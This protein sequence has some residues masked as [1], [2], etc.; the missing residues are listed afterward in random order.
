MA[1]LL[2]GDGPSNTP[3]GNNRQYGS[4]SIG[5]EAGGPE[6]KPLVLDTDDDGEDTVTDRDL[7]RDEMAGMAKLALPLIATYLLEMLP[8]LVT[9]ILVG[10][11]EYA[12]EEKEEGAKMQKLHLDATSFAVMFSN[13]VAMAPA[14]GILTAMDTLC[15]QAHGADQP[16][17]MGTYALTGLAVVS[18]VFLAS[19]VA[20]WNAALILI[21][22]GQ[23]VEV[24][25][26]AGDFIRYMIPGYPFV[27]VYQLVRKVFEARNEAL[28]M[29]ISTG[30]DIFINVVVGYYMVHFTEWGWMGA[31][32]AK[33][34]GNIALVPAIFVCMAMLDSRKSHTSNR[35]ENQSSCGYDEMVENHADFLRH[36][37]EGFVVREALSASAFIEFLSLGIPGMLQVLFEWIAFEALTLLCGLLPGQEAIVAIG[38]NTVVMNLA[39]LIYMQYLGASVAGSVRIGN[40]L[41]AGDAH[42]AEIASNLTLLSGVVMSVI[43]MGVLLAFCKSLPWLFTTDLDIVETSQQLF[44]IAVF[45]QLPDAI[46]ANIQAIF[47]GSGRQF[48]GAV[49][50]FISYYV[51]GLPL[52]YILGVRL[53]SGVAGLWW[54]IT[55][56]M[57]A[58]TISCTAIILRSD[59]GELASKAA[60]RLD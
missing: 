55:A 19:S 18:V 40:A 39:N 30:V 2:D 27:F 58:V 60:S 41:G 50:N 44:V 14:D 42:R 32:I 28:P 53:G 1:A 6:R 4:I 22:L 43:N 9:I 16:H 13:I 57:Y 7:L 10:R 8:G 38:A 59:W 23:P 35:R 11:V 21:S 15:S 20:M 56:G 25:N 47:R 5:A 33:T 26:L 31:A 37:W 51:V 36:L 48:Q 12:D 54:G 46:N 29:L 17:K 45:F 3:S 49:W 24:S 34:I 52:A